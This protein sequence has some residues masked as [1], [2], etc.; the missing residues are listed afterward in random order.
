M[1]AKPAWINPLPQKQEV[2][3]CLCQKEKNRVSGY[4]K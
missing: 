1:P 2:F 3:F 4:K